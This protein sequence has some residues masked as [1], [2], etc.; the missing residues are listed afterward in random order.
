MRIIAGIHRGR[1]LAAP[2]TPGT[3]PITDR[4]KQSLFDVL[5][6]RLPGA[7]VADL[8]CGTGSLGLE[9]LSRGAREVLFMEADRRVVRLLQQNIEGLHC[10]AQS[11]VVAGD[12]FRL[13]PAVLSA[14]SSDIIFLDPP[15]R[16]LSERADS[17]RRLGAVLGRSLRPGGVLVFRHDAS[18]L[19]PLPGLTSGRLLTYGSMA[20][21]LLE[22]DEADAGGAAG[23]DGTPG[24]S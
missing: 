6:P 8:F 22:R 4:A 18:D 15:Y 5:S 1:L 16:Y 12:V 19:L 11:R 10:Q 9:C 13:A 14:G 7:Q 20:I 3:R 23:T 2:T 24:A 21:E 17:L